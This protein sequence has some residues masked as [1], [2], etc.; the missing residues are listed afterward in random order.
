MS[1]K[2]KV[3]L[4]GA[5]F[6]LTSDQDS[7]YLKEVYEGYLDYVSRVQN[8][9]QVKDPLK[10]AIIAGI[11][12]AENRKMESEISAEMDYPLSSEESQAIEMLTTGLIKKLDDCLKNKN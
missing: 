12:A 1:G 6:T 10:V 11:L 3:Q 5:S 9:I 7:D 4:L 2:L 8:E